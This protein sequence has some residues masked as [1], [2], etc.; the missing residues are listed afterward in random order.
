MP[1]ITH[2]SNELPGLTFGKLTI[3]EEIA[4]K[5]SNRVVMTK[6]VCGNVKARFLNDVI[7]RTRSC[8]RCR[9]VRV[10][11]G[12]ASD[13]N[14]SKTYNTWAGMLRRCNNP[15][16][17][18]YQ[19]YGGRGIFVCERWLKFES[20]LEDM[21]ISEPGMELDRRCNNSGYFKENC[22]W[23]TRAEN[24]R[25]TRRNAWVE[26]MGNTLCFSD[27]CA[28]FN[29]HPNTVNYHAKR[30]RISK[31]EAMYFLHSNRVSI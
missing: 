23:V 22:R 28:K 16:N 10:K 19:D 11:H 26:F 6:C 1:S 4:T 17:P 9:A 30:R 15:K 7:H 24:T 5:G 14:V 12:H 20:F 2:I 13:R 3:V 31:S 27:A 25:N 8:I 29:L 21:G 18:K